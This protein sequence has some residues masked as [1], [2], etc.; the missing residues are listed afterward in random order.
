[1]INYPPNG[2]G[3]TVHITPLSDANMAFYL[4]EN[5]VEIETSQLSHAIN[6]CAMILTAKEQLIVYMPFEL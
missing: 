5:V 2:T 3:N 6:K 4:S 1:M